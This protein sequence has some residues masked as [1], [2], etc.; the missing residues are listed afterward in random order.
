MRL[1]PSHLILALACA[2]TLPTLHAVQDLG[3]GF[4]LNDNSAQVET[5]ATTTELANRL[6]SVV[7]PGEE[8]IMLT[9]IGLTEA[10]KATAKSE[11]ALGQRQRKI[12]AMLTGSPLNEVQKVALGKE[13]KAHLAALGLNTFSCYTAGSGQNAATLFVSNDEARLQALCAP[14]AFGTSP[15][16]ATSTPLSTIEHFASALGLTE[17]AKKSSAPKS[18]DIRPGTAI[19]QGTGTPDTTKALLKTSSP[20]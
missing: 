5:T 11:A 6:G 18:T 2:S 7:F 15:Q 13:T 3:G 10:D 9:I 8:K 12:S 20:E 1:L 14:M 19:S 16:T 4:C 17:E